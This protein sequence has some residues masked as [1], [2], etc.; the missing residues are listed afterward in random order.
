MTAPVYKFRVSLTQR[1]YR[2]GG[3]LSTKR[4]TTILY[5]YKDI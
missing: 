1:N 3:F 2:F 4:I 5:V